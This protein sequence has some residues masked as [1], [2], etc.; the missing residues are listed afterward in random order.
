MKKIFFLLWLLAEQPVFYFI[1]HRV[2]PCYRQC[3]QYSTFTVSAIQITF[4]YSGDVQDYTIPNDLVGTSIHL[5]L[6]G[7]SGGTSSSSSGYGARIV[8]TLQV[9]AG[10]LL[11]IYVGG[12]SSD[13]VGGWN[14]GG[15]GGP[16]YSGLGGGG[17]SDIRI[18]GVALTNR[19]VVAGGG[20]GY[21]P[22]SDCGAQ[23]GGNAGIA[24]GSGGS[25]ST[26]SEC[27]SVTL[28]GGGGAGQSS[29]GAAGG[30]G[31]CTSCSCGSPSAGSLGIGGNA[32]NYG[33]G[34]GGGYYGWWRR[35]LFD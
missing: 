25:S 8:S 4:S 35:R 32:A 27:N 13:R 24:A 11:H 30:A 29:G 17:A 33:G 3:R 10:K 14:G 19:V 2:F 22:G 16:N 7:A 20:G 6:A 23:K 15:Y 28:S 1:L 34:G 5:D 21:Y 26:C 31:G 18:S 9:S 12:T